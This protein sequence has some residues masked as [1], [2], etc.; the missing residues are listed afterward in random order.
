MSKPTKMKEKYT[1]FWTSTVTSTGV[2]NTGEHP[3]DFLY[4]IF[5]EGSILHPKPSVLQLMHAGRLHRLLQVCQN[6]H[7]RS[8]QMSTTDVLHKKQYIHYEQCFEKCFRIIPRTHLETL[9]PL[10][11][12]P[13]FDYEVAINFLHPKNF[14]SIMVNEDFAIQL[15]VCDK[16]THALE[17][18]IFKQV[19]KF[20]MLGQMKSK[21]CQI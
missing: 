11:L 9:Y 17:R 18:Y 15:Y 20:N 13:S 4:L 19:S 1:T 12:D 21:Q 3:P 5:R 16:Y 6:M 8:L 7:M 10:M 2:H 14:Y